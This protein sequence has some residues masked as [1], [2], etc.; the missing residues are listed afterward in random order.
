MYMATQ[1]RI[2]HKRFG[3][4]AMLRTCRRNAPSIGSGDDHRSL[5]IHSH[6]ARLEQW[7]DC[8]AG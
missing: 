3:C 5:S 8:M 1:R 7:E 2:A 6:Q 4:L